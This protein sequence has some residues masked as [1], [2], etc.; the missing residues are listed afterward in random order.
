MAKNRKPLSSTFMRLLLALL[1]VGILANAYYMLPEILPDKLLDPAYGPSLLGRDFSF[2]GI[3]YDI[4]ITCALLLA[5]YYSLHIYKERTMAYRNKKNVARTS[6]IVVGNMPAQYQRR[7]S[8]YQA[9][10][11][12]VIAL[13]VGML[14][15]ATSE[16]SSA[17]SITPS[18]TLPKMRSLSYT[19]IREAR[20]PTGNMRYINA[21]E[22]TKGGVLDT[23][24][25]GTTD[26][27]Y[28]YFAYGG[29]T[30]GEVIAKYDQQGT[31]VKA[32]KV[33]SL[34]E[35]GH[36][37]GITYDSRNNRLVVTAY[38]YEGAT[39]LNPNR[40]VYVDP[41]TLEI[42]G[43]AFAASEAKI[44]T[45]CYNAATD[46]YA[47]NG[48]LFDANFN[49]LNPTL[50]D[51]SVSVMQPYGDTKSV[52]QGI[53]CTPN[54]IYVLRYYGHKTKPHTHIY[55][56]D[57]SGKLIAVYS[58]KGLKDEGENLILLNGKMYLGVNNGS[59]YL[60][61]SSD[62]KKDYYILLKN[63]PINTTVP[64]PTLRTN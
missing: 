36:A 4:L 22:N 17:L 35:M 18:P 59:T 40:L 15:T 31:L 56:Y 46:Q 26:G 25:G 10:S 47:A 29:A 28:L 55:M 64:A 21:I 12:I 41:E 7:F 63:I 58:I 52:G 6:R 51:F 44:S 8:M 37:N 57:W 34:D 9:G 30:S 54:N 16:P 42:T 11:I 39:V 23:M 5:C 14:G 2:F 20:T 53:A 60:G 24:Q 19:K 1:A 38:R 13:I 43:E 48:V 62:N 27:T 3:T 33:Y 50:Y 49:L 32:S 61:K 45:A